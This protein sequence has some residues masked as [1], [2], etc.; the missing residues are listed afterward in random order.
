MRRPLGSQRVYFCLAPVGFFAFAHLA[1]AALRAL[2]LRCS[3]VSLAALFLPPFEPPIFP[4]ATA[5]GFFSRIQFYMRT[6]S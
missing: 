4:S 1:S 3:G 2:T 5:F 6:T